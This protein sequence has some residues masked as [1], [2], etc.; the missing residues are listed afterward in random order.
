MAGKYYTIVDKDGKEVGGSERLD[1][2]LR[3]AALA[4]D[5]VIV[6]KDGKT[7]FVPA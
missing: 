2:A 7:V 5:A 3:D 4:A 6:D 1:G